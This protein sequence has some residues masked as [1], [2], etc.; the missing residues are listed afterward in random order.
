MRGIVFPYRAL[1]RQILAAAMGVAIISLYLMLMDSPTYAGD[2]VVASY[3][4]VINPVASE[5]LHDALALAHSSGAQALIFK[6][7]TPGGLD[8][9]MHLMIK[10]M[11]SSPLLVIVFVAPP[12]GRTASAGVFIT[13]AAR[14]PAMAPRTNIGAAHPVAMGGGEMDNTMKEK[15]GKRCGGLHQEHR[16]VAWTERIMGRRC[17]SKK[18][19]RHRARSFE[20]QDH[21]HGG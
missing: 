20:I 4:G 1:H 17:G 11:T 10:E 21:R 6:L 16:G 15:V 8:T 9:S 12:G 13:L 3:E 18:Y 19:I 2:I 14:V 7:D 5:Y